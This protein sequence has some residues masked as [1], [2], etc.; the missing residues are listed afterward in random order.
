[1]K[2]LYP[3]IALALTGFCVLSDSQAA[4]GPAGCFAGPVAVAASAD[5]DG[6]YESSTYPC[7]WVRYERGRIVEWQK[8]PEKQKP[9]VDM[10][11]VLR[12]G[13]MVE[14]IDGRQVI[15]ASPD[16]IW[17][18]MV[19]GPPPSDAHKW[20][21]SVITMQRCPACAK[22]KK[23]WATNEYLRAFARPELDQQKESW[24][25]FN[26]YDSAD[27]TQ[28]WRW[29]DLDITG[30]PTV[31]VT[32]P[33]DGSRGKP[34][35]VVFQQTYGMKTDS[36][37]FTDDMREAMKRYLA[38][39][40]A[41]AV[42]AAEEE[43]ALPVNG[44]IAAPPPVKPKPKVDP[45][46]DPSILPPN[47]DDHAKVPPPLSGPDLVPGGSWLSAVA[48]VLG[49]L[50]CVGVVAVIGLT[51]I[52]LL[53]RRTQSS[54]AIASV[55]PVSRPQV[56]RT[57]P[58]GGSGTSPASLPL[59]ATPEDN[60]CTA[61]EEYAAKSKRQQEADAKVKTTLL[62]VAGV[63]DAPTSEAKK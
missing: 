41:P 18:Q 62:R 13:D 11:A 48:W 25:H 36:K 58:P 34:G 57:P 42:R 20:F 9:Q 14:H 15:A 7:W 60:L 12:R 30:F 23:D 39:L 35:T 28:S 19:G 52:V 29:K 44:A 16:Q 47:P 38:K 2:W 5:D 27:Q 63:G 54:P 10:D 6:W 1:M 32:P 37:R 55:Q 3:V 21:V 24:A 49:G 26:Y 61:L 40:P 43:V 33:R 4:W 22:L 46:V 53:V 50:C 8:M 31:L 45:P 59:A 56:P 17:S 51:Y